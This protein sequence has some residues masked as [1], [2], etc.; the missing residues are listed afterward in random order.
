MVSDESKSRAQAFRADGR[1]PKQVTR[2]PGVARAT[3]GPLVRSVAVSQP[4][5]VGLGDLPLI[6]CWVNPGWSS[7]LIIEDRP[8]DWVDADDP[9]DDFD[10]LTGVM[11]A[12]RDDRGVSLAGFLV[13][14]YC[15]GAKNAVPPTMLDQYDM[16][17]FVAE[18]FGAYPDP[19]MRAPIDLARNLVFGAVDFAW[20]LGFEPHQDYH[21]AVGH[22]GLW[23]PPGR[24]AFGRNGRPLFI[25]GPHDDVGRVIRT[26]DR[27]VG[28]GNYEYTILAGG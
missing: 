20:R 8:A 9:G 18:F 3:V 28:A 27:S 1:T 7:G 16:P 17:Y 5:L 12:R 24:I 6:G 2:E 15:L 22:L 25:Q 21:S 26:L 14:T 19:P 10:G 23:Q 13:D 11:V 4:G